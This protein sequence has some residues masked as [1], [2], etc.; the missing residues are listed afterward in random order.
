MG[1]DMSLEFVLSVE[2][3]G[4]RS[5]IV[6]N[7]VAGKSFFLRF[8]SFCSGRVF[9]FDFGWWDFEFELIVV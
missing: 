9:A 8:F 1:S 3:S 6:E 7:V 5:T 2:G 4:A